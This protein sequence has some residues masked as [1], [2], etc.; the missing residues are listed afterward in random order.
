MP[1]AASFSASPTILVC[2]DLQDDCSP[3]DAGSAAAM[4]ACSA[5][6]AEWRGQRWPVAHLKRLGAQQWQTRGAAGPEWISAFRPRADELTFLHPLPSAYSS[7]HFVQYMQTL[8]DTACVLIGASLDETILATAVEGFHRNHRYYLATEAVACRVPARADADT[9]RRAVIATIQKFS[10]TFRMAEAE[11]LQPTG[12]QGGRGR[13]G[14]SSEQ[15]S[16]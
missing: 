9:Y 1:N 10:G 3:A 14:P 8:R 11:R 5:L 7:V 6:L 15:A 13:P 4:A 2:C 16:P 12:R